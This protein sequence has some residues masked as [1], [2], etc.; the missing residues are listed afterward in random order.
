MKKR[1]R[2]APA[3]CLH[4]AALVS[5]KRGGDFRRCSAR[6]QKPVYVSPP[7]KPSLGGLPQALGAYFLWTLYPL[8]FA[9]LRAVSAFE[10]VAWR[11]L[12][13]LPF[14]AVMIAL[15]RQGAELR[16]VL[17][18]PRMLGALGLSGVLIGTNWLIYVISV[19][20]GHILA[21][22]LG[23]YINPLVSVLA[24]AVF[25]HERL[26]RLRI[27]AL[28]LAA[29]G[30]VLLARDALPTLWISLTLAFFIRRIRPHPQAGAGFGADRADGRNPRP[31]GT[32]AGH[33]GMVRDEPCGAGHGQVCHGQ[34]GAGL[35]RGG[36]GSAADPV[37]RS[38]AAA[39]P[40]CARVPA[41]HHPDRAVPNGAGAVPRDPA[42]GATD[43][44]PVHLDGDDRVLLGPLPATQQGCARI[45]PMR[46]I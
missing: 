12:F 14:C 17:R 38:R 16:A 32:G 10:V 19:T 24:G 7:K 43:V 39:G 31:A 5:R 23:Y 6:W 27:V 30:V 44:L 2:D 40:V 18:N 25:L 35:R 8:Y 42:A 34:R 28:V 15:L 4:T 9:L 46:E 1:S 37:C 41:V 21:A 20:H 22:S 36:N 11:M 45:G 33:A 26:S 13:T 3:A 29:V